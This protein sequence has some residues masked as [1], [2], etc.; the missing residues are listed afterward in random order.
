M[1]KS[2]KTIGIIG[3]GFVGESQ[4]FAFSPTTD[5]RIYDIDPLKATHTLE[6]TLEQE[7]VFVCLPTPMTMD[8]VQD[9]SYIENFFESITPNDD[10]I[11][12]IKSTVLPGTTQGL[13]DKYGYNIVFSPEFLTERTAK[14]DML[15]QAR[16]I[17]GGSEHLTK[18]VEGLFTDRFMNR[19]IIHTNSTTAE[20]IKYMNNTF[21]ATKVAV[22]NEFYRLSQLIDVD[23]KTALYGFASDGRVGDS[24]LHVPGPD[25]RLGY[26]G[27]CFPKD[28]NAIINFAKEHGISMNAIEGGWNTNVEVRPERD[29]EKMEGRAVTK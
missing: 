6:E 23:W 17:F 7:F 27:T 25:G 12:I 26:G 2:K 14:L 29:W 4:A 20:Y 21:F 16:I 18:R 22:M 3:N 15:T 9:I 5:V 10:T 19:N 11:F 1:T 28:V 24:H 8:G 13:V